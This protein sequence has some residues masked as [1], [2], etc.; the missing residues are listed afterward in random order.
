MAIVSINSQFYNSQ[1]TIDQPPQLEIIFIGRFG[2]GFLY[3][4]REI[5]RNKLAPI[6]PNWNKTGEK[7][8]GIS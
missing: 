7:H 6:V 8:S 4:W 5:K 2:I 3:I 1:F